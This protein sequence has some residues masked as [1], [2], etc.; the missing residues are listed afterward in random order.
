VAKKERTFLRKKIK[1][2]S[3]KIKHFRQK[4]LK[5]KN[6]LQ[7]IK[8]SYFFAN[9]NIF[10]RQKLAL[11]LQTTKTNFIFLSIK[12]GPCFLSKTQNCL[13][14]SCRAQNFDF[15]L[16]QILANLLVYVRNLFLFV[17]YI[18]T[19]FNYP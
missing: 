2:F 7:A 16:Q 19:S 8:I 6:F 14:F 3:A 11:I 12:I 18:K 10:S 9:N 1:N 15:P 4:N 13:Y 5:F 17:F